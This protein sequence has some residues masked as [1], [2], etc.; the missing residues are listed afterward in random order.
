MIP[1]TFAEIERAKRIVY[2]VDPDPYPL[3]AWYHRVREV[4]LNS[5]G[6]EDLCK[7]VRQNIYPEYV[8]PIALEALEKEPLAGE[9]YD[10]ELAMSFC[11]VQDNFW[12]ENQEMAKRILSVLRKEINDLGDVFQND[13]RKTIARL[14]KITG[15]VT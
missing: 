11:S 5:F 1:K 12:I 7:S 3:P 15:K 6:V 13:A 14:E 8:V 10:G 2:G 4:P 9:M